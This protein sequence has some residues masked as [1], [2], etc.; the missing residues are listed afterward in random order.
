MAPSRKKAKSILPVLIVLGVVAALLI[1]AVLTENRPNQKA[2]DLKEFFASE[3]GSFP[4]I[5]DYVLTRE[6]FLVEEGAVYT[7][8]TYLQEQLNK[9]FF[10]DEKEELL[11]YTRA[12]GTAEAGLQSRY[13]DR[14]VLLKKGENYYA[15]LEYVEQFTA[16]S[17]KLY[18]DPQRLV[19]KTSFGEEGEIKTLSRATIRSGPSVSSPILT[20]V[21]AG[22]VLHYLE[23]QAEWD[24]VCTEDGIPGFVA[25]SEVSYPTIVTTHSDYT[26]DTYP[27]V[28]MEGPVGLVWHMVGYPSDNDMLEELTA[29]V[30]GI[31]VI[32]PTWLYLKGGTG[33]VVSLA[34]ADYVKRAHAMGYQ[35]WV[36]INNLNYDIYGETLCEN[37][38]VSSHRR[39]LIQTIMSE[40]EACGADGINVD[41]ENLPAAGGR[42]FLQFLREL[43]VET[44]KAGYILSVDNYVPSQWTQYY[45]RSEQAVFADYL[46]VM[47][48]DEHYAGS[49]AGSTASLPFVI[50]GVE[51]TLAQVP[52]HKVIMAVPFFTRV[53]RGHG[54]SLTSMAL[55]MREV[56]SYLEKYQL[57]PGWNS[58]LGQYYAEFTID[59]DLARIWIEDIE[60][61]S[62]RLDSLSGYG[63]AG[64]AAWR[65]GMESEEVWPVFEQFIKQQ[66]Q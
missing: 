64:I 35:V 61:T 41:I 37:F 30:Q 59:G 8:V 1:I 25:K 65:L 60:S 9:R 43:S 4:V 32:S 58:E 13:G 17:W 10:F 14:P 11:L 51:N 47:A 40:L 49:D 39:K 53:W 27:V 19:L 5:R 48:Y 21:E 12:A 50:Q 56:P 36:L 26:E 7:S 2:V 66:T 38:D 62:L 45:N 46:V 18:Q 20:E 54:D 42:G 31:N 16:L 6:D 33:E 3:K 44:H 29:S 57:E 63:L 34:D 52:A 24:L 23:E 55:R 28:Q 15:L 22:T